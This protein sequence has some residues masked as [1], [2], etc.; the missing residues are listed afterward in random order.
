M[1]NFFLVG[2]AVLIAVILFMLVSDRKPCS[3][4]ENF[5]QTIP[6]PWQTP[7]KHDLGYLQQYE[8]QD[9]YKNDPGIWPVIDN[10]ATAEYALKRKENEL[11]AL[12]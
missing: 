9:R 1:S 6:W 12:R 2:M 8:E 11:R 4:G 10:S 5:A 7:P 3:G